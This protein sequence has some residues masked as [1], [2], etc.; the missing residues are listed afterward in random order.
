MEMEVEASLLGD[1]K[2]SREVFKGV[3]LKGKGR[4][5]YKKLVL[6]LIRKG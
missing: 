6:N 1:G 5:K 4:K 2:Y 3:P